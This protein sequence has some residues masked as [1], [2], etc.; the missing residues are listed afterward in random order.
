MKRAVS[1]FAL[2]LTLAAGAGLAADPDALL[3]G[4]QPRGLVSDFAGVFS[5]NDCQALSAFLREVQ[6]KTTAEIAV[7]A[8]PALDGGEINDF[9]N[10]LFAK[11]GIGKKGKDNG[12]LLLT[13][14]EDRKVR[15]EVGYGLE[16][17]IPDAKAGRILD[18]NVIP[19]FKEGQIA[20]GLVAGA[21][22]IAQ[23]IAQDV[24]VTVTGAAPAQ[25]RTMAA[26][27]AAPA[28]GL[29]P[30]TVVF[31]ILFFGFIGTLIFIGRKKGYVTTGGSGSRG[32]SSGGG[33]GGGGGFGGGSSG[34]GG[35]SRGW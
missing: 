5:S 13:A 30:G 28:E 31:M 20:A 19:R 6:E 4:L 26:A 25:A 9:A 27:T 1:V 14:I 8:L 10:R 29:T 15:I 17:L 16:G 24:G 34:G 18:E 7:V 32:R 21:Q 12:V 22:A 3:A 11:W 2:L 35:A 23:I 33:G